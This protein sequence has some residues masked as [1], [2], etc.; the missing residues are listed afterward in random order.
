MSNHGLFYKHVGLSAHYCWLELVLGSTI[1]IWALE[2]PHGYRGRTAFRMVGGWP[3]PNIN[4]SP[5]LLANGLIPDSGIRIHRVTLALLIVKLFISK[6]VLWILKRG[7]HS[8]NLLY[9][10]SYK[11]LHT[12]ATKRNQLRKLRQ[13]AQ[14]YRASSLWI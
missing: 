8:E 4:L 12:R 13:M 7:R 5:S 10:I 14:S 6:I 3:Q 9:Q 11:W 1:V 2:R